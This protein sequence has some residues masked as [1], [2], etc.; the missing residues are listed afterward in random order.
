VGKVK[1]QYFCLHVMIN[2]EKCVSY[3][4]NERQ[5]KALEPEAGI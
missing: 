3:V 5:D 2:I 1:Q 4:T